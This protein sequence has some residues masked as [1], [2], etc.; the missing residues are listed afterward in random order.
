L[1]DHY[2]ILKTY[3]Y[4]Q[5]LAHRKI[6]TAKI[7]KYILASFFPEEAA[8]GFV[9]YQQYGDK[10]AFDLDLTRVVDKEAWNAA[11]ITDMQHESPRDLP[12]AAWTADVD[13]P[14]FEI[15]ELGNRM[16]SEFKAIETAAYRRD[17]IEMQNIM[18]R[19]KLQLRAVERLVELQRSAIESAKTDN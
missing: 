13:Q 19:I 8:Y 5:A 14:A 15:V 17:T 1:I 7:D 12:M 11:K 18:G 16:A 3:F 4:V 2:W 6:E 10:C 9:P